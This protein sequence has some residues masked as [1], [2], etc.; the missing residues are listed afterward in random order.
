MICTTRNRSN[1]T[2]KS[3]KERP[4]LILIIL[5]I[6]GKKMWLL[7]CLAM[8]ESVRVVKV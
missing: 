6:L 7:K 3:Q 1:V 4:A 5:Y 2:T 8:C